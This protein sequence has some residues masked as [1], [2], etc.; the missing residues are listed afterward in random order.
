MRSREAKLEQQRQWYIR[1]KDRILARRKEYH[2]KVQSDPAYKEMRKTYQAKYLQA[3]LVKH[4][5]YQATRRAKKMQ[6]T[7]QWLSEEQMDE[8]KYIYSVAKDAT[9]LTGEPYHVDHIVPL[10]GKNVCGLHVPW[11][12]QILP[13]TENLTKGN[14]I[15]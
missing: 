15:V 9:I 5:A 11:N 12:L 7:P 4:A 10:K 8:I 2:K 6:A 14:R 3:N 1:N 13:A